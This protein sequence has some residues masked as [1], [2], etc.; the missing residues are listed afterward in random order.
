[1]FPKT[2]KKNSENYKLLLLIISEQKK[3]PKPKSEYLH[4]TTKR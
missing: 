1:M 2:F 3:S 4:K